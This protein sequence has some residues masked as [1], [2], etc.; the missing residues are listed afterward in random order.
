MYPTAPSVG[1]RFRSLP[2]RWRVMERRNPILA[3]PQ[4]SAYECRRPL[5]LSGPP[6]VSVRFRTVLLAVAPLLV[7]LGVLVLGNPLFGTLVFLRLHQPAGWEAQRMGTRG[8]RT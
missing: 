2:C 8:Y 3:V 5:V 6:P 1:S 7:S 4:S